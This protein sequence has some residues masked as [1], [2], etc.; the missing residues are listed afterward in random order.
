MLDLAAGIRNRGHEVVIGGPIDAAAVR[1]A[2]DARDLPWIELGESARTPADV[3]HL[4]LNN[5]LE[6]LPL[7]LLARRRATRGVRVLTEHLP[8]TFRTDPSLPVDPGVLQRRARPG[9]YHAKTAFKR[10]EYTLSD[11][12]ITPAAAS[13][14]FIGRRYRLKPGTV[15]AIHN[16]IPVPAEPAPPPDAEPMEVLTVG[17]LIHRKGQDVLLEAAARAV[18]RW[19]VTF[20][21][22]GAARPALERAAARIQDR[23]VRFTGWRADAADAPV[24][25]DVVCVPSRV[26]SLPY[27]ALEAMACGRAVVASS[28]DGLSEI[29]EHGV[30]G[31]LV[32]PDDPDALAEALDALAVDRSLRRRMGVAAHARAR[33][34][35]AAER[36]VS[37]TL[38]CYDRLLRSG[39]A[40]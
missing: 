20:I 22:E 16:G 30:T 21:G 32:A 35:F 8:R 5:S 4:H 40:T 3:W 24:G 39:R 13:A 38:D 34:E 2:A 23:H 25:C 17:M 37:R 7:R 18:E 10:L 14:E 27:V 29:V 11:A 9:A 33:R 6:T 26:E 36:M 31:R 19:N 12:V 15:E 1:D 28:I